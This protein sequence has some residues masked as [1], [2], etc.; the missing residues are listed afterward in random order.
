M[1][2][3]KIQLSPII[4]VTYKDKAVWN[5]KPLSD[6]MLNLYGL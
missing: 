2:I 1:T 4:G 6:S 3:G 5:Y